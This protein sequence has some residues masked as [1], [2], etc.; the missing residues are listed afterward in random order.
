[1]ATVE[2]T[3]SEVHQCRC[4]LEGM[5]K[6]LVD[7]LYGPTGLPWGVSFA[8]LERLAG[9]LAQ[10][11]RQRFLHLAL[12]RQADT[13]LAAPDPAACRCPSCQRDTDEADPEPRILHCRAGDAEWIEPQRYCR[14]CRKAFFPQSKSLGIDLGHYSNAVLDLIS[15]A[16]ANQPSFRE[17]SLNLHKIGNLVV[18]EKQVE[19]LSKRIG[20]ERLAERDEQVARFTALPLVERLD[21]VPA[22]VSPPAVEQ[23]AVVMADAGMLQLRSPFILAILENFLRIAL[24]RSKALI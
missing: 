23:V 18:H 20:A 5:A 6:N 19:R 2:K 24:G 8:E 1:M 13:F 16:G 7:R 12:A 15:Y 3:A 17:A 9:Q 21:G 10:C 11:L 14:H 22:G 4:L